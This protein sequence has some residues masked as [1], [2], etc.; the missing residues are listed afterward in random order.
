MRESRRSA[1]IVL[2]VLTVIAIA[3]SVP[4]WAAKEEISDDLLYDRVNRALIVDRELGT[5]PLNLAVQD[6]KVTVSGLVETEKL[7]ERVTKVV[8]KVKGVREVDNQV[9]V[10]R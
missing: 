8:K 7:R 2:S 5:T 3:V 10:R 1:R 4:A 9:K 6:G